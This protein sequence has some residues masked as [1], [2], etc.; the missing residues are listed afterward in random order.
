MSR[1]KDLNLKKK[2][3]NKIFKRLSRFELKGRRGVEQV[4][5]RERER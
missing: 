3:F 4:S 2:T 1:K 5:E